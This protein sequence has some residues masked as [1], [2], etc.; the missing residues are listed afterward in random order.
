MGIDC[1]F[2]DTCICICNVQVERGFGA[3]RYKDWC[4]WTRWTFTRAFDEDRFPLKLN[5]YQATLDKMLKGENEGKRSVVCLTDICSFGKSKVITIVCH[6]DSQLLVL[7]H[8]S[9]DLFRGGLFWLR[10]YNSKASL[11]ILQICPQSRQ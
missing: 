11:N 9:S 5:R 8:R 1:T 6:E 10:C 2:P 4:L 7:F 3:M